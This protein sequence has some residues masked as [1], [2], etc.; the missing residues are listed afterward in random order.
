MIVWPTPNLNYHDIKLRKYSH[1]SA[2]LQ[3]AGLLAVL[4]TPQIIS[5]PYFFII[6]SI[7]VFCVLTHLHFPWPS[8]NANVEDLFN[9][10]KLPTNTNDSH[11]HLTFVSLGAKATKCIQLNGHRLAALAGFS[12][13]SLINNNRISRT[14]VA[15][16]IWFGH[17]FTTTPCFSFQ[18]SL[19]LKSPFNI[20]R[21]I[22]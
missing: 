13:F 5:L 3:P 15:T 11:S 17:K 14:V 1:K 7:K 6:Y 12:S 8:A 10:F 16:W 22:M 21:L 4:L 20:N 18:M 2:L 19:R 9:S